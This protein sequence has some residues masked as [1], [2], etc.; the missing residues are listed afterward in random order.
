MYMY[1]FNI[2]VIYKQNILYI[3]VLHFK[4]YSYINEWNGT[5]TTYYLQYIIKSLCI[6]I[7]IFILK[8]QSRNSWRLFFQQS[9]L[10]DF[11]G[12]LVLTSNNV[13]IQLGPLWFKS[14]PILSFPEHFL[15]LC[16]F[17]SFSFLQFISITP[18]WSPALSS[19]LD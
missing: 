14:H 7:G 19:L 4:R 12:V 11:Q 13:I 2:C 10:G 5:I 15:N 3:H 1:I 16:L 18:D 17:L 6:M 8:H 9:Y